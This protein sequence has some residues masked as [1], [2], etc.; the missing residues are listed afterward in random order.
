MKTGAV[1]RSPGI[2]LMTGETPGKA[3]L[4]DNLMKVVRP[5]IA[6][7]GVPYLQTTLVGSHSTS[8]RGREKRW[9]DIS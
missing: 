6:S 2:Y 1:H 7:N 9:G 4:G 3:H 5:D 8:E